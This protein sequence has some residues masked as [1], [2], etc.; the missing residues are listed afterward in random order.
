VTNL[1][2]DKWVAYGD[3][4]YLDSVNEENRVRAAAAVQSSVDEVVETFQTGQL[5][6]NSSLFS[7]YQMVPSVVEESSLSAMFK[8]DGQMLYRRK[9]LNDLRDTDYEKQA[10]IGGWSSA[11]TLVE[12]EALYGPPSGLPPKFGYRRGPPF[13]LPPKLSGKDIRYSGLRS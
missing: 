2:G 9:D 6:T 7:T 5:Q 3:Q 10:Y 1:G 12:L 13:G 8:W 4:R 11:T